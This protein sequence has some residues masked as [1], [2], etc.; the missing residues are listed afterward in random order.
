[1][2]CT[3]IGLLALLLVLTACSSTATDTF[4]TTARTAAPATAGAPSNAAGVSARTTTP[5]GPITASMAQL[6]LDGEQYATLGDPN[7]PVTMIEFSD[8]G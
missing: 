8:Y 3:K 1:M 7:A 4:G 2:S 5:G 6:Q